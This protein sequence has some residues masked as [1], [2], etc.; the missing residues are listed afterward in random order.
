MMPLNLPVL[1][2]DIKGSPGSNDGT[3]H[4]APPD[5]FVARLVQPENLYQA[6]E[7]QPEDGNTEKGCENANH[8]HAIE[9]EEKR[10]VK[11]SGQSKIICPDFVELCELFNPSSQ[12]LAFDR[13]KQA[14]SSPLILA[15]LTPAQ[16]KAL[17]QAGL[18]VDPEKQES[19]PELTWRDFKVGAYVYSKSLSWYGALVP[20]PRAWN[21][22]EPP[23]DHNPILYVRSKGGCVLRHD[24]LNKSKIPPGCYRLQGGEVVEILMASPFDAAAGINS[25]HVVRLNDIVFFE[26]PMQPPCPF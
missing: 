7:H 19:L 10:R 23:P 17:T 9:L 26:D 11:V 3:L 25:I 2:Y 14:A 13:L 15:K 21:Y 8:R 20:R 12:K 4:L 18:G 6:R 24:L 1:V 22:R 5:P 16:S